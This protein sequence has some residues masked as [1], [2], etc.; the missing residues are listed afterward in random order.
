MSVTWHNLYDDGISDYGYSNPSPEK[1]QQFSM[2]SG[3]FVRVE[4]R[5]NGYWYRPPVGMMSSEQAGQRMKGG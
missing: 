3:A 4:M 2:A 5:F 1:A